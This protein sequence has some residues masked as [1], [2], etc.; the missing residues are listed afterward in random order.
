MEEKSEEDRTSTN[1]A[2]PSS[3]LPSHVAGLAPILPSP[4]LSHTPKLSH[5]PPHISITTRR[6]TPAQWA[7]VATR[8]AAVADLNFPVQDP[9]TKWVVGEHFGAHPVGTPPTRFH[10]DAVANGLHVLEPFF[11]AMCGR[12][13]CILEAGYNVSTYTPI[14]IDDISRVIGGRV[15][16]NLQEEFPGQLPDSVVQGCLRDSHKTSVCV[17]RAKFGS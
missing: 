17:G 10:P 3:L 11:G 2:G 12:L 1:G 9:R 13:R 15:T 16:C 8:L 5:R 6:A 4:S 7:D 14:E